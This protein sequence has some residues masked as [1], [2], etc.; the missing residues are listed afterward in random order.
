MAAKRKKSKATHKPAI[1][2]NRTFGPNLRRCRKAAGLSQ[3]EL[4]HLAGLHRTY[5]GL[6]E[7]G[8]RNP[9]YGITVK[10]IGA[11]EIEP[12]EL[13]RGGAWIPPDIGREGR[14]KYGGAES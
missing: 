9:G 7:R 14:F 8:E 1:A 13:Y 2:L 3:E 5:V 12:D 6:L 10:L 11:L 4:A